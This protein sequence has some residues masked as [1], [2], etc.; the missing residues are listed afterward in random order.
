[1][2]KQPV[3][4]IVIAYAWGRSDLPDPGLA[5]DKR[6][7][8]LRAFAVKAHRAALSRC[9]KRF[10]QMKNASPD[11]VEDESPEWTTHKL[12]APGRTAKAKLSITGAYVP[13]TRR[14]RA[15]AGM[16]IWEDVL[17]RIS[18]ADVLIFDLTPRAG[19]KSPAANVLLEL[20]AAMAIHPRK[21][22]FPVVDQHSRIKDILPS[23]LAGLIV[24]VVPNEDKIQDRALYAAVAEQIAGCVERKFDPIAQR[25]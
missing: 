5:K 23:D 15:G 8:A 16:F 2:T 20:G 25:I 7:K 10:Q 18:D 21:P 6:W 13:V 1:M 3:I 19:Q 12:R 14:L 24:G 11:Y 17:R 4:N 9:A 22:V